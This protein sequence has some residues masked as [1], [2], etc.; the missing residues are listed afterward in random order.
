VI[1]LSGAAGEYTK[2]DIRRA[3]DEMADYIERIAA[4]RRASPRDD[5]ISVLVEAEGGDAL[6]TGELMAFV[7]LL[8]IAGNETTTNLIGNGVKALLAHP[9]QLDRVR[10]N[11]SLIPAL[12]EE[13]VRFDSPIQ[14]LPRSTDC[15]A[16]LPS[17]RVPAN[18]TLLVFFAAANHDETQFID[19]ERFDVG[20]SLPG[21]VAFGHGIHY[22]LGASLARLEGRVAFE[23]L[24]GRCRKMELAADAVPMLDSLVLRGPKSLSLRVEME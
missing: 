17:G 8:L 15:D 3:A 10:A 4:D 20:R 7:V 14:A 6:S 19:A 9:E 13:V 18:S 2:V 16:E 21:H 11:P 1:G 23:V 22:C 12:V 24:L 5:L